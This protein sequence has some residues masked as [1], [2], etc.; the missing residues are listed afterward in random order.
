MEVLRRTGYLDDD[1]KLTQKGTLCALVNGFEI[2]I[3]EMYYAGVYEGLGPVELVQLFVAIVYEPRRRD[4]AADPKSARMPLARQ[5]RR[6]L[7]NFRR[8]EREMGLDESV[9]ELCFDLSRVSEAWAEGAPFDSVGRG[10]V[11]DGDLVRT[12]RLAIQLMRQLRKATDDQDLQSRLSEAVRRIN[13]DVVDAERQLNLGREIEA[14]DDFGELP[15]DAEDDEESA[16]P[17]DAGEDDP[18]LQGAE[19]PGSAASSGAGSGGRS[20]RRR[21]RR[22]SGRSR[23]ERKGRDSTDGRANEGSS[24]VGSSSGR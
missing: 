9:R 23:Q 13:R 4:D 17:Y 18:D 15:D 1:G 11:G 21:R 8:E 2:P 24:A 19:S 5:A 22:A 10:D 16:E 6:A 3:T 12:F 7:R 14:A 20:R